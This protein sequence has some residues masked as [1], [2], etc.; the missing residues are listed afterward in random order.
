MALPRPLSRGGLVL[1]SPAFANGA[2]IP[3]RY[4]CSGRGVSPPLRWHGV[5]ADA[6]ELALTVIDV[7]APGGQYVHWTMWGL[8]P[9]RTSLRAGQ[10]PPRAVQ[11]VNSKG[12]VGWTPPCPPAGTPAHH[13]VFTLYALSD[14]VALPPGAAP[15][16]LLRRTATSVASASV[17]GRFGR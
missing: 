15:G 10:V 3:D 12:T 8:N 7:E 16:S 13:Y 17:I 2:R 5:P 11:G 14:A 4:S 9:R 1:E 6:I